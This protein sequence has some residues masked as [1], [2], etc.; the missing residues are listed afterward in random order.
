MSVYIKLYEQGVETL[1]AACD[2]GLLGKI[3]TQG[4]IHLDVKETFYGGDLVEDISLEDKLKE[5]TIINLVGENCV[6]KAIEMGLGYEEDIIEVEDVPH[7][8]IFR[9]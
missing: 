5:A 3:F 8:Q 9:M 7:L 2:E 4:E 6:K 1:L